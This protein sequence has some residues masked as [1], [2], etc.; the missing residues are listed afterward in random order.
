MSASTNSPSPTPPPTTPTPPPPQPALSLVTVPSEV[1]EHI[2]FFAGTQQPSGPPTNL[3]A[4][5]LTS[6]AINAPLAAKTNPHLYARIFNHTFD[7]VTLR[8]RLGDLGGPSAYELHTE[9]VRRCTALGRMRRDDYQSYDG[10]HP[11]SPS[12][13]P[14]DELL[15][16]LWTLYVMILE[17]ADRNVRHLQEW[18]QA[19]IWLDRYWTRLLGRLG[20]NGSSRPSTA[21]PPW[22]GD[23][24]CDNEH[25]ALA[26]WLL[27]Y[28]LPQRRQA[29]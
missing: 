27:W 18:A 28:L 26:M 16:D 25:N 12:K 11:A 24:A 22:G 1:L 2:A 15:N 9:L 13:Q 5:L 4:L 7:A 14:S 23:W 8:K 10:D 29:S 20:S 3:L 6:R 17:N 19:P 21:P